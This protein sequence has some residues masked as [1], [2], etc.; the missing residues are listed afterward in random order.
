M[1]QLV[2]A[3]AG[4]WAGSSLI[5]GTVLGMTGAQIGWMAGSLLGSALAPK[6]K[7]EGPRL[8][9]LRVSGTE[10]GQPIPWVAGSPRISG[11]IVWAST[12]R[13]TAK[14]EEVGKGGG[15]EYTTYTYDVD[16]LILLT[17]NEIVGVSRI[18]SNGE[19][20][21]GGETAKENVWI[22]LRVYTG[23][24]DQLPDPTYEA[25]V[26]TANAP[27]YRGRGYVFIQGLQLGSGGNIP[28]LTFEIKYAPPRLYNDS[29]VVLL[30]SEGLPS[31]PAFQDGSV[32]D[33][34]RSTLP[35]GVSVSA[36]GELSVAAGS[37]TPVDLAV[38]NS[39][40]GHSGDFTFEFEFMPLD[41][42]GAGTDYRVCWLATFL[43]FTIRRFISAP[44]TDDIRF[45]A[46]LVD[47]GSGALKTYAPTTE[48]I[49]KLTGWLPFVLMRIGGRTELYFAGEKL[50]SETPA[51]LGMLRLGEGNV[52]VP[53]PDTQNGSTSTT[54]A[55]KIRNLRVAKRALY[56]F[57]PGAVGTVAM[58]AG[59]ASGPLGREYDVEPTE[60]KLIGAFE[61]SVAS[62]TYGY[63][64]TTGSSDFSFTY[65][66]ATAP[67][68]GV[69]DAPSGRSVDCWQT[70]ALYSSAA[71]EQLNLAALGGIDR[72]LEIYVKFDAVRIAALPWA[73]STHKIF[74]FTNEAGTT[75]KYSLFMTKDAGDGTANRRLKFTTK[76]NTD[77]PGIVLGT[78]SS[79]Y[80]DNW[81]RIIITFQNRPQFGDVLHS[82]YIDNQR[83][84]TTTSFPP[85]FSSS[86]G[87]KWNLAIGGK[88]GTANTDT[89][90]GYIGRLRVWNKLLP[91]EQ[92]VVG[93]PFDYAKQQATS[94]LKSTIDLLM[95]RAG[96]E[97]GD[98]DVD[99]AHAERIVRGL[100]L[101]QVSPTRA[102]LEMLQS[103]F[104]FE[105]SKSDR[106]YVRP[107]AAVAVAA[108]PYDDLGAK[109]DISAD[110]EPLSLNIGNELEIPAQLSITYH[111]VSEDYNTGTEHSDRLLTGQVSNQT[112]Q[113]ALGMTPAEAKGVVDAMLWDSIAGL[114][115]TT[116]ALPLKYAYLEPGDVVDVTNNDARQ[117]RL[118][119]LTKRDTLPILT[120]EC[121]LDDVNALTSAEVTDEN[122][123]SETAPAIIAP[124]VWEAM[125]IPILR[126][127]DNA[128]GY[129]VAVAPDRATADDEWKGAVFV[130]SWDDAVYEQ[131]F[132][133]SDQCVLGTCVDVLGD[134][135]GGNVFDET[136]TLTVIMQGQLS[137]STRDTMLLDL[138][139]NAMLVGSEVIRFRTATLVSNTSDGEYEYTLSGLV[140]GQRGTEWAMT[141]HGSDERCVLLNTKLRR[142]TTQ[143][144]QIGVERYVKAITFGKLLSSA[145][146]EQFTDT[147][148]ALKPFSP[149][150]ARALA[151]GSDLVLTWQRRTRL[152]YRYGGATPSVP[153]GEAVESYRIKVYDGSTLV[154]TENL[155]TPT[156][157]YAAAD[158]TADGFSAGAT[159][160]FEVMQI[161]ELVGEGY[162]AT[163]QGTA[164]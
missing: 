5:T 49:D 48:N 110:I 4:A 128:P 65:A 86:S 120:F 118:R 154:R 77:A 122:Y 147:G 63:E 59:W 101:S 143:T 38:S 163:I 157:T 121:T 146:G 104:F 26:G 7:A 34:S 132:E 133:S 30:A 150:N 18:W 140:R 151:D 75:R 164:P 111:N 10:Y 92:I 68:Y 106:L 96:Y 39:L 161:S 74:E 98:Y 87:D 137:S 44:T 80:Y 109:N 105:A 153:L 37:I 31:A 100:A 62:P 22:D 114:T 103:A 41:G 19:L 158:I 67:S 1:A 21:Y 160:T 119:I 35:S 27:A 142:I 45:N 71:S 23:A 51:T 115:K 79:A 162:A 139:V 24:A 149:A 108:I 25:A 91:N 53:A 152:S 28:N 144:S 2:I 43:K 9:D 50:F 60:N 61:V 84:Y 99:A 135:T 102:P 8:N 14:T 12:R 116:L 159:V 113:M 32:Y 95:A 76:D 89:F 125:D 83:V 11:Q 131:M 78:A 129:Y 13:E 88:G 81:L 155:S 66:G 40:G 15:A 90:P 138:S 70:S 94:D 123:V 55:F 130:R 42:W 124:T 141:G 52:N 136:N 69:D 46:D 117:Y 93:V 82:L 145:T 112:V 33:W 72:A 107:R 3:A 148:V 47:I 29:D 17:E 85:T 73:S 16:L 36:D 126:D 58:P 156:W 134:W 54:S 57:A 20:V 56:S 97:E 6:Q 127:A 64:P